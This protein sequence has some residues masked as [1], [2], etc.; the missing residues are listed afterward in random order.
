ML[1]GVYCTCFL[2]T[3][4]YFDLVC[5]AC[6]DSGSNLSVSVVLFLRHA[7]VVRTFVEQYTHSGS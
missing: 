5:D 3:C 1:K 7:H 2:D 6:R 4:V